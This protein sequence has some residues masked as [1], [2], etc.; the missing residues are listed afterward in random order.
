MTST[1]RDGL[2]AVGHG[3][4]RLWTAHTVELVHACQAGRGQHCGR[5]STI[6]CG[7]HADRDALYA[8]D[9]GRYRGH[10]N[11]RGVARE[12][13]RHVDPGAGDRQLEEVD[14]D[15]VAFEGVGIARPMAVECLD[16]LGCLPERV[17]EGRV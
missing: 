2:G 1:G 15:P 13:T 7:R 10:E 17:E 9:T 11:G 12:P 6:R 5:D 3:S 14:R 8:R 4:D 16:G